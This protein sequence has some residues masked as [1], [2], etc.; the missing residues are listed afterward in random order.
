M[1]PGL[2]QR[3][4]LS[5]NGA[6]SPTRLLPALVASALL[7]ACAGAP[8]VPAQSTQAAATFVVV[9]HAEKAGP[10][11]DPELAPDGLA[12]AE[13]LAHRLAGEPLV[14]VYTT[15][16]RRTRATVQPAARQHA[17]EPL[18][19]DAQLS[20]HALAAQLRARHP[21]GTVLVAGHSN[22]VPAIVSALC[23]CDTTPMAETEY[24]RIS[25]VRF[26]GTAPAAVEVVRD[27]IPTA[28]GVPTRE[29]R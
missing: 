16:Y 12:R 23:D 18:A 2:P 21:S 25:I 14:A 15:D 3:P 20:A 11:A 10:G 6:M 7:S 13:R 29:P 28:P 1:P 26:D 27:P 5:H 22:T 17:L 9:R 19:Y 24:D 8:H 4:G